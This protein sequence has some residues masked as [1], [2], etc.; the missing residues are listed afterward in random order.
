MNPFYHLKAL[1]TVLLVSLYLGSNFVVGEDSLALSFPG[2]DMP[3]ELTC[4]ANFYLWIPQGIETVRAVI[5]HQH[6]C[7]DGAERGCLTEAEDLHWRALAKK[8]D[9][10]L[11]GTSYRAGDSNCSAWADARKGSQKR[12]HEALTSFARL[13]GHA[14]LETAPW[15]LWGHSGGGWWCSMMLAMEPERCVA[16]WLRSGSAYGEHR[17]LGD[18]DPPEINEVA[19]QVPVMCNPGIQEKDDERFKNSYASTWETFQRWRAR[20]GLV[21]FAADPLSN[22]DCGGSRYLAIP[23]FD[24]CLQAR[25]PKITREKLKAMPTGSAWLGGPLDKNAQ[26]QNKYEGDVHQASWL[27]DERFARHYMTYLKSASVVDETRPPCPTEVR[28]EGDILRWNANAD[29]ET[30]IRGFIIDRDGITIGTVPENMKSDTVFQG[31]SFHDTPHQPVPKMEYRV[32]EPSI[33]S[34]Y[35]VL[36]VNTAGLVSNED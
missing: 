14:E 1:W 11:L 8:H 22:H 32:T 2:S 15:C 16:V 5:V 35:R 26:P 28:L 36:A 10:A 27:P 12:F 33:G 19:L 4:E 18:I 30:G 25:L 9:C 20:S 23:F 13:S 6:G 24:A 7:G 31:L 3:G 21:A 34:V 29:L 17:G